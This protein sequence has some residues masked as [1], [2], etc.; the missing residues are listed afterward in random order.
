MTAAELFALPARDLDTMVAEKVRGWHR[1]LRLDWRW[2][3]GTLA[4]G[5]DWSCLSADATLA[6]LARLHDLHPSWRVVTETPYEDAGIIA[7]HL[8]CRPGEVNIWAGPHGCIARVPF[9]TV[10]ELPQAVA[11]AAVMAMEGCREST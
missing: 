8:K 4:A 9:A 11:V 1:D 5:A 6:V 10:A 7:V 2:E 3:D